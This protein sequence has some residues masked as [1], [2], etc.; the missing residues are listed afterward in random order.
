MTVPERLRVTYEVAPEDV[1]A[2]VEAVRVEQTIEF[3][4]DLAPQWV[5]EDVVGRV[6]E[7]DG[8]RVTLSYDARVLDA[9][10]GLTQLLNVV[11]GNVSLMERVRVVAID[12]PR[13]LLEQLPGPRFGLDG[14]RELVGAGQRP[15]LMTALKPMGTSTEVLAGQAALLAEAGIDIVKDDHGLA[16]QPWS[17][18]H[19]RVARCAE[20][21][22]EANDRTGRRALYAPSLN[23]PLDRAVDYAHEAKDQGAG[24][25]L[26]MPGLS[27]FEL[28]RVL[29]A[30]SSLRLPLIAHPSALGSLTV[31]PDHGL[32]PGLVHGLLNRL[33]GADL[34][35]FVNHGGRFGTT[36]EQSV[37]TRDECLRPLGPVARSMPVPGGGMSIDRVGALIGMYG[38]D[39][40]F[41]VGG[42]LHRG[43]LRENAEA[44]RRAVDQNLATRTG[45]T[46]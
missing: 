27:S 46:P 35:V 29:A 14:V 4:H 15:L 13:G 2:T 40:A 9:E 21:V 39:A 36:P 37:R 19:E 7:V 17:P 41:L 32:E 12:P 38:V 8:R 25:L 34:C 23:V 43:D 44:L 16:N 11:W 30:D 26:V 5:Q 18:W 33:A 45:A 20:A 22:R 28:L 31:N 24:A 1:A 42:A 6:E 3:P 10:G